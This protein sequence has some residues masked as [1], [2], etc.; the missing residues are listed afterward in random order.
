MNEGISGRKSEQEQWRVGTRTMAG[1]GSS[2]RLYL[3][4]VS[5][6]SSSSSFVIE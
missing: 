5:S 2:R 1:G 6:S 4:S 3:S